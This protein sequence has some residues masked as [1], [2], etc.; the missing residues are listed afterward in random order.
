MP[1]SYRRATGTAISWRDLTVGAAASARVIAHWSRRGDR[2]VLA[3]GDQDAF[4]EQLALEC[5]AGCGVDGPGQAQLGRGLAGEGDGHDA[6]E[7]RR[8]I[9]PI[10]L[11]HV[12]ALSL[13]HI[14]EPT[15]LG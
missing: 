7:Q 14:S 11:R 15:R 4:A 1:S 6:L 13:I 8:P 12:R 10:R 3:V 9:G 2:P 5:A